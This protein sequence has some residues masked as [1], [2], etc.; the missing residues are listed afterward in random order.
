MFVHKEKVS[1]LERY[2]KANLHQLEERQQVITE[3]V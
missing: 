2:R 1:A 3:G